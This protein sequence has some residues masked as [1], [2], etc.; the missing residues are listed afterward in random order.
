MSQQ[1]FFH[2]Y[3]A[4]EF[5]L[6]A[7]QQGK[8]IAYSFEQQNA[9]KDAIES[10]GP[11]HPEVEIVIVNGVSVGWD[12]PVQDGDEI[13]VYPAFEAVATE[14]PVRLV[15]PYPGRPRFIL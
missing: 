11:P 7:S 8:P 9:V 3:G 15:P 13:H 14:D 6:H 12:H 2:F 5:F 1:A 10:L 4:L